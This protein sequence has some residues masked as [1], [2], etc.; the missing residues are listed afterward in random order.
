VKRSSTVHGVM[1][2]VS[3]Q[4]LLIT[5]PAGAGK[6][7]LGLALVCLGHRL[8]ADDV[9]ELRRQGNDLIALRDPQFAGFVALRDLG[10]VNLIK[11]YGAAA[12]T[13]RQRLDLVLELQQVDAQTEPRI[14]DLGGRRGTQRILE[15]EIPSVTLVSDRGRPLARLAETAVRDQ[16]ARQRGY[17]AD[18]DFEAKQQQR[19]DEGM[20]TW[21]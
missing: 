6:S 12:S 13:D 18:L 4:G 19:V 2:E 14:E 7:E 11:I 16:Q 10:V 15:L 1:L 3:G 8:V 20:A 17:R 5:G 21:S 9:V